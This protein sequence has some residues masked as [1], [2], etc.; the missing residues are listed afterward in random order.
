MNAPAHIFG[1][2]DL[3]PSIHPDAFVA[4]TATIIGNVTIEAGASVWYGCVLR[5]EFEPIVIGEGSN[6]QD[7]TIMHTDP[8]FPAIVGNGVTIGH[9]AVIHGATLADGCLVGLHATVLNGSTVGARSLIAAGALVKEGQQ[10]P[11]GVLAAGVPAKVMRELDEAG[12]RRLTLNA[13]HYVELGR[14][15]ATKRTPLG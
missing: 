4:E 12:L 6:V 2:G 8:G 1:F 5:S 11:A 9:A 10:I 14:Q 3:T 13:E 7:G 15:H